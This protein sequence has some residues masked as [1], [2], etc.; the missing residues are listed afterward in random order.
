MAVTWTKRFF[1]HS[2][3]AAYAAFA[4]NSEVIAVHCFCGGKGNSQIHSTYIA[5]EGYESPRPRKKIEQTVYWENLFL[6]NCN[7]SG[8]LSNS[9][10]FLSQHKWKAVQT[11]YRNCLMPLLV[12]KA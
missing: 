11:P 7:L 8:S 2:V 5:F 10:P 3:N 9:P 12:V 4:F 6:P 1:L